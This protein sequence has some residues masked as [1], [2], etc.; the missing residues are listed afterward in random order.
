MEV[1]DRVC[2]MGECETGWERLGRMGGDGIGRE[3]LTFDFQ[4]RI[5]RMEEYTLYIIA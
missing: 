2:L 1:W 5:G 3:R 4:K